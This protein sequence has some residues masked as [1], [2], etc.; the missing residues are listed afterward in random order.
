MLTIS[1]TVSSYPK[2][3]YEAMAD[4]VLGKKYE[5]SLVFVGPAR[6]RAINRQNRGKDY[7]PNVLSFPLTK[8]EGEIYICP[9]VARK[10]A[11]K[12]EMTERGYIGYLFLHG[13]LH[14]KGLDHG[15]KMDALEQK[16]KIHFKLK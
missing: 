12:F 10:E 5:V 11:S 7:I 9:T 2:L 13:L 4:E 14:L 15:A 3:P 8:H 16:F 1:S 6:A